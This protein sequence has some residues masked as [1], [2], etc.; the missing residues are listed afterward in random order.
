MAKS[1]R[2]ERLVGGTLCVGYFCLAGKAVC[3][4]S[5]AKRGMMSLINDR[6]IS[7]VDFYEAFAPSR[8]TCDLGEYGYITSIRERLNRRRLTA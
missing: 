2:V 8:V 3:G 5:P 7:K 1:L 6:N 4:V